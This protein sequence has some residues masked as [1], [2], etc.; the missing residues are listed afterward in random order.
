[1]GSLI[2]DRVLPI[3]IRDIVEAIDNER[4]KIFRPDLKGDARNKEGIEKILG[5]KYWEKLNEKQKAKMHMN[6]PGIGFM[7]SPFSDLEK[8]LQAAR[9]PKKSTPM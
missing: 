7:G 1:M 5:L 8:Q 4:D 9:K 2:L 3:K 6:I